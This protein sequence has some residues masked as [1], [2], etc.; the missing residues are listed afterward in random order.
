MEDDSLS[1]TILEWNSFWQKKKK[2]KKKSEIFVYFLAYDFVQIFPACG[3]NNVCRDFRLL[4]SASVMVRKHKMSDQKVN[5]HSKFAIKTL[6]YYR[7]K[8]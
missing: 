7:C 3:L 1:I 6:P 5:F 4:M 2:K 8:C